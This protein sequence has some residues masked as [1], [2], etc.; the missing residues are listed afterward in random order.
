MRAK[1]LG[2]LLLL[3]FTVALHAQSVHVL[4]FNIRYPNPGD[5]ENY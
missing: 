3:C 4:F 5:G 2:I 1:D